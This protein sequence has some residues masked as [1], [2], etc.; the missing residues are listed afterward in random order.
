MFNGNEAFTHSF[1]LMEE[2][3]DLCL[4]DIEEIHTLELCKL[5]PTVPG[6]SHLVDWLRMIGGLGVGSSQCTVAG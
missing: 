1:R 5:P 2:G 4:T 3:T 6:E